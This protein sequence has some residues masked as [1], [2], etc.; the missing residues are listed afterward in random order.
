L[1]SE[2]VLALGW[3]SH[4]H[5]EDPMQTTPKM[6]VASVAASAVLGG[7][8][9]ALGTAATTSQASPQA[10]A[11]AVQRVSDQKAESELRHIELWVNLAHLDLEGIQANQKQLQTATDNIEK[12]SYT[13]CWDAAAPVQR[14][15][16]T[17]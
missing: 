14:P 8:V 3:F 4:N 9:G 2:A 6:L 17:P 7:T 15:G 13:T 16:C 1:I 5:R 10:I 12:N 11:A